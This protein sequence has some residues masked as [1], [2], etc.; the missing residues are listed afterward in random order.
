MLYLCFNPKFPINKMK[1][2][3]V[4][5]FERNQDL[6]NKFKSIYKDHTEKTKAWNSLAFFD[7]NITN[8][9]Y[10]NELDRVSNIEYSDAQYNALNSRDFKQE[11]LSSFISGL[12]NQFNALSLLYNEFL[13]K[14][15]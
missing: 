6:V 4:E 12:D 8:E 13:G 15:N 1:K 10:Y 14:Y 7:S 3:L 5:K 9:V 2:E 11:E